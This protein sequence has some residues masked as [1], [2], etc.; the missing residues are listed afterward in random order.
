MPA[1]LFAAPPARQ[2]TTGGLEGIAKDA[3]QQNLPGVR[4]QVRN[5][6]GQLVATGTTNST[7]SFAFTGMPPGTYTIELLDAAGNIVG[8]SAVVTVTAGATRPSP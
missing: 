4:V 8:T 6:N 7:G 2:Q 5:A 1:G 3:Q